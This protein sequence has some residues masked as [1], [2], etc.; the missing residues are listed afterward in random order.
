MNEVDWEKMKES[1]SITNVEDGIYSSWFVAQ[2]EY[3]VTLGSL[4]DGGYT[5]TQ[6]ID[7][8]YE[9]FSETAEGGSGETL[10]DTESFEGTWTPEG[11]SATGNWAKWN[12]FSGF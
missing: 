7:S 11:W 12:V 8:N 9:V 6:T 4:T 10:I 3:A 5:E 1:I 2:S